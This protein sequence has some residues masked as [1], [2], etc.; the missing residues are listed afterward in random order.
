MNIPIIMIIATVSSALLK[1][2]EK[3]ALYE[4]ARN[5]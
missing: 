3:A 4:G 1:D 2:E 5:L